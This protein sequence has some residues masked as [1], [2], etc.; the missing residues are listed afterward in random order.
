MATKAS[1]VRSATCCVGRDRRLA[2]ATIAEAI[3]KIVKAAHDSRMIRPNDGSCKPGG[4]ELAIS[5]DAPS[6]S[7]GD[8]ISRTKH[9]ARILHSDSIAAPFE[10][11]ISTP[12]KNVLNAEHYGSFV[13]IISFRRGQWED[14]VLSA[15]ERAPIPL[16]VQSR[17][18][19]TKSP[20]SEYPDQFCIVITEEFWARLHNTVWFNTR[21]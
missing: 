20:R 16:T 4:P 12:D 18:P 17:I 7:S 1:G 5:I 21:F 2:V 9:L 10:L 13:D 3:I 15:A 8:P 19:M 6:Y 14:V 11:N